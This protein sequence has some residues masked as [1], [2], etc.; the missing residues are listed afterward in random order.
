MIKNK[1]LLAMFT[2]RASLDLALNQSV[3]TAGVVNAINGTLLMTA[4]LLQLRPFLPISLML[5]LTVLFGP[6]SGLAISII[7]TR[8]ELWTGQKLGGKASYDD[9]YRIFTW[10]FFPAGLAFAISEFVSLLFTNNGILKQGE[11][12]S[13]PPVRELLI[14]LCFLGVLCLALRN[15]CTNVMAAN[16]FAK[17]RG[18]LGILITLVLFVII[19]VWLI[20]IFALV[21]QLFNKWRSKEFCTAGNGHRV[22]LTGLER[23]GV[24]IGLFYLALFSWLALYDERPNPI[25]VK[26]LSAP[27]PDIF[28]DDNAWLALL[29]FTS[30][31]EGP[32]FVKEEERLRNLK[33]AILKG[34][35]D[36][37]VNDT[38]A[39]QKTSRL[40]FKGKLPEIYLRKDNGIWE[41]VTAHKAEVDNFL[42]ENR[43]LLRRYEKLGSYHQYLEPLDY[44]LCTP[45]PEISPIRNIQ[46][47]EFMQIARIAQHGDFND[48]LIRI[49]NDADFWR[50]IASESNTLI[51]KL[52]SFAMLSSD[53]KFVAE[54]CAHHRLEPKQW[55]AV[56]AILRPFNQEETSLTK[57]FRGEARFLVSGLESSLQTEMKLPPGIFSPVF[58]QNATRN[59]IFADFQE[60]IEL[61]QMTAQSYA[62][63]AAR[64]SKSDTDSHVKFSFLYNPVGEILATVSKS[65]TSGYVEKR[66]NLEGLRRLALLKVLSGME[67]VATEDMQQFLDARKG[68]LGNPFTGAAMTWD[69]QKKSIYFKPVRDGKTV[70]VFM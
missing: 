28:R 19:P 43:V 32:P 38:T 67:S 61:S 17:L 59:R 45:I 31:T 64:N 57:V 60:H 30:T 26:E 42:R 46:K 56:Q 4:L 40:S 11:T 50:V 18:A 54:L 48:A 29:G 39:S 53:I 22:G 3:L 55:K 20:V 23:A 68:D 62:D 7:Y 12:A 2:P 47:I 16:R 25:M 24:A 65:N 27:A 69:S 1:Y 51:S 13:F 9:L 6:F 8:I 14:F 49:Q 10:S 66:H 70:E 44:G 52:I 33:A 21:I 36:A 63:V 41:Y 34:Q 37:C 35:K 5:L 58:K 15:Y